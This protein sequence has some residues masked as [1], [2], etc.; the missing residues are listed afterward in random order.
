MPRFDVKIITARYSGTD[1]NGRKFRAGSTIAWNS[2]T[3]RVV[4]S[5]PAEI[6][7]IKGQQFADAHDMAWE[8]A[9]AA[10]CGPGL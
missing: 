6:D 1:A 8:D 4:T 5:D 10:A 7:R 2:S 3:R 9:C